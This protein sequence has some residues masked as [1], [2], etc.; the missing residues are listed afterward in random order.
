[1]PEPSDSTVLRI[2]ACPGVF[3]PSFSRMLGRYRIEE[4]ETAVRLIEAS[5][6]DQAEGLMD[7]R[8]SVGLSLER[9]LGVAV[10][11]VPLWKEEIAVALP[12]RSPLLGLEEIPLREIVRYPLVTWSADVCRSLA[13]EIDAVLAAVGQPYEVAE[14]VGSFALLAI[15]VAAGC[16]VGLAAR[17]SIVAA[18]DAGIV[19][20]PL[21]GAPR[22]LTTYLLYPAHGRAD[23]VSRFI[24]RATSADA[25]DPQSQGIPQTRP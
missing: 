6:V 3:G 22:Y 8:Y 2:A 14:E 4:P 23:Y 11:S 9:G 7:G 25:N 20:R 13:R 15:L 16:G 18:R 19:M 1:M 12:E 5:F 24:D 17:S 10:T 21:A